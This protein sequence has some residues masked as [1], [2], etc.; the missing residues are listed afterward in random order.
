V[1]PVEG[2][3]ATL[4]VPVVP[5]AVVGEARAIARPVAR[6]VESFMVIVVEWVVFSIRRGVEEVKVLE[7]KRQ[8]ES[9][10]RDERRE[11]ESANTFILPCRFNDAGPKSSFPFTQEGPT[12][13]R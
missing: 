8:L 2:R 9:S 1:S 13:G 5:V 7:Q 10:Y 4:V 6:R 3:E 11:G 12:V